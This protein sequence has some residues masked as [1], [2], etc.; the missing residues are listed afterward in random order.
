M[1]MKYPDLV[2]KKGNGTTAS[3]SYLNKLCNKLFL[4][5]WCY[6]NLYRDQG[7]NKGKDNI[8]K[9][10][11]KELCDL[12]VVFENH[13]FIFSD[14]SCAFPESEDKQIGWSRWYKKTIQ[15]SAKQIWGAERWIFSHPEKI[16]LDQ[17]CT[18]I[19]P[20]KI[21]KY[22]DAIIHRIVVAHG[23]SIECRKF[24]GGKGSLVIEPSI[25]GDDHFITTKHVC[26]PFR[27]GQINP[28]MGFVHIFDDITLDIILD[29][30]DTVS[31]FSTYLIE[32]EKFLLSGRL[33]SAAGEEELLAM[34]LTNIKNDKHFFLPEKI[35][36]TALVCIDEGHWE[37]F[38]NHPSG[39]AQVEANKVSYVWDNIFERFSTNIFGGTPYYITHP[40]L[41]SQEE[42]FRFLAR[43]NRLKRRMLGF[44]LIELIKKTPSNIRTTRIIKPIEKDDPFYLYLLL[45]LSKKVEYDL[46][47]KLRIE[48]LADYLEVLKLDFP[49]AIDIIGIGT[50][51]GDVENRSED[52]V[53]FNARNWNEN[54]IKRAYEL[55]EDLIKRNL[56]SER[57]MFYGQEEEY[58]NTYLEKKKGSERNKP[59]LCGSGKKYKN[60]CGKK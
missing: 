41:S 26:K 28:S 20:L 5:F 7:R 35:E 44:R 32:K 45:P 50:E 51:S 21:P 56:L 16:Y 29:S 58:P 19:F 6:P 3:E 13:V 30:L 59:C 14:K 55:K 15:N 39:E 9:G 11:G 40:N 12:L 43:Q 18:Q 27:I 2:I 22:E 37:G 4:S 1:G 25:I 23:A 38:I 31:D 53:Y 36:D 52:I 49:E 17:N 54:D 47:R 33:I 24:F 46:Y 34:F 8:Y 10:D 48:L 57:T 42:L 60:C